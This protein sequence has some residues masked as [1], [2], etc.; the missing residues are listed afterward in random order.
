MLFNFEH[1]RWTGKWYLP[2]CETKHPG[3]LEYDPDTGFKLTL[4]SEG[5]ES[6]WIEEI[7]PSTRFEGG[8]DCIV[9]KTCERGPYQA[10]YGEANG[11]LLSLFDVYCLGTSERVGSQVPHAE[12]T[13]RPS[14][15]LIGALIPSK[16]AQ[17]LKAIS[18]S[19]D[20]LHFWLHDTAWMKVGNTIDVAP[21]DRRYFVETMY[22]S[23]PRPI[24]G[25]T[26]EDGTALTINFYG[27]PPGLKWSSYQWEACGRVSAAVEIIATKGLRSLESF[28]KQIFALQSLVS[29]CLDRACKAFASSCELEAE[30]GSYWCDLLIPR[31]GGSQPTEARTEFLFDLASCDPERDFVFFFRK[32]LPFY[33]KHSSVLNLL[34]GLQNDG[35]SEFLETTVIL[36]NTL[37]EAFHRS[38]YGSN[39]QGLLNISREIGLGVELSGDQVTGKRVTA[40]MRA[41]DLF[42]RLPE[43]IRHEFVPKPECWAS[44]LVKARNSV[45]HEGELGKAEPLKALAAAR[46][47]VAIVTIHILLYLEVS[48]DSIREKMTSSCTTLSH[49]RDLASDYFS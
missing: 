33:E 27:S 22:S 37:L 48:S 28:N 43:E 35:H 29:L 10:I 44:T 7:Q 8:G 6:P 5:F 45:T 13:Y 36:S 3:V 16:E 47:A 31:R 40:R 12:S 9:R 39:T 24:K 49:A 19:I 41:L 46:V 1:A 11:R 42:Y 14:A 34:S 23:L 17:A 32:W 25:L 4:M 21:V 18:V 15:A 26:L 30:T 38:E 2:N 20:Y